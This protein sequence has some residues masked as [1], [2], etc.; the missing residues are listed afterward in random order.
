MWGAH[1]PKAVDEWRWE[2]IRY[3]FNKSY[4]SSGEPERAADK[5]YTLR[6]GGLSPNSVL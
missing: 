3:I 5:L 6:V 2:G 4:K 1:S